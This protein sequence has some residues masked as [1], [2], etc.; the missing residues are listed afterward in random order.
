VIYDSLRLTA[1]H[2][3]EMMTDKSEKE[4]KDDRLSSESA[5]GFQ[6]RE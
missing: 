4:F 5:L 3:D 6:A 1:P 2:S